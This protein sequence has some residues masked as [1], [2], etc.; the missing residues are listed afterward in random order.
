MIRVSVDVCMMSK[1]YMPK[2]K[3]QV[4]ITPQRVYDKIEQIW[5]WKKDD[6]FDPCPVD[7][8]FDGLK[9]PWKKINY[10]NPPFE[11]ETLTAFVNKTLQ[12]AL[13]GN[14]TIMLLPT[15]KTDQMWWGRLW[16]VL[17]KDDIIW[18]RGRL[19]FENEKDSSPNAHVLVRVHT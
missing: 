16:Q 2:S 11:V 17:D 10:V 6:M 12:E 13:L 14:E 9:I 1:G 8:D 18:F 5:G 7:P 19:K 3:S 15:N 4:H